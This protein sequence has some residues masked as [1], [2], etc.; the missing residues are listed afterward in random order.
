MKLWKVIGLLVSFW[1]MELSR[2]LVLDIAA[3]SVV[4]YDVL[5]G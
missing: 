3:I 5:I 2:Y 1:L 4:S